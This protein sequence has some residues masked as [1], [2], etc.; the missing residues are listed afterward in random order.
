MASRFRYMKPFMETADDPESLAAGGMVV[1]LDWD[2]AWSKQL[3]DQ[4]KEIPIQLLLTVFDNGISINH[5]CIDL[6]SAVD[7]SIPVT[8]KQLQQLVAGTKHLQV[9]RLFG[10]YFSNRHRADRRL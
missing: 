10:V 6:S 2:T 3:D 8:Q 9:F 4:P 7:I 5:L 1:P